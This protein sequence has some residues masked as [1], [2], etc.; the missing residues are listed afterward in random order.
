MNRVEEL[1]QQLCT[2]GVEWKKLGEV[3]EILD[4]Q[5]RPIEKT[6]RSI[7]KY[8]YYGANGI[9][10]YVDDFLFN[11][12]F[13]L[14]GEDGS[15]INKDNSPILNWA[16]G[17]IWVNNHAHILS[18]RKEIMSLRFL[19]FAL[20]VKDISK[21]VRGVPPKLNQVNLRN[22]EIPIPPLPIQQEIVRILDTFTE[23]STNLQ[24]ELE[25][26]KKQYAYYRDCLLNFEDVKGV[27][28]KKL[29][30]IGTFIRGNG[31]QKK[32]F[33]ESGIG[34]IH[35]GQIYTYYNISTDST[36]SYVDCEL[37]KNLTK[38]NKGDIIIACTSE[39]IEDICK[40]VAWLG[41][42]T[43][44]TGGHACVFK[45]RENPKF[46]SYYLQ[47]EFFFQ[48]KK[49]Y[50]RGAKVIDIKASDL[51]KIEIPIPPLSEQRRI[52]SILDQFETL[53]NDLSIGLPA[54]LEARRK[55]YEYYRD[56]LLTFDRV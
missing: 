18:E 51:A 4:S 41:N 1:I 36:K 53:V 50:A 27:E 38:V 44:V 48:Q 35:Y 25:A 20:S 52:V 49:K 47:S 17:K 33:T 29:G 42:D 31:L 54:E 37:A 39:N 7:G 22:I 6:K 15:V 45:H 56:K 10:D 30:E 28:W 26:R 46:I 9:Q 2:N 23:L 40:A 19:Y 13:L 34:C 11:G 21:L 5:R 3:C 8:P 43:I 14:V 32:D 55:Q 24:T 12:T 16:T